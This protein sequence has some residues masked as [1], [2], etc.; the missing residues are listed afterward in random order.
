MRFNPFNDLLVAPG[1]LVEA[2]LIGCME[3]RGQWLLSR[4]V[5][6]FDTAGLTVMLP[7]RSGRTET[8]A[9]EDI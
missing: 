5:L 9:I 1:Y 8:A 4:T 3:K 6:S 2:F 7:S